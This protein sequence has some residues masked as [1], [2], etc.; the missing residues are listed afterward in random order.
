LFYNFV[1]TS[2]VTFPPEIFSINIWYLVRFDNW[3]WSI[4]T[5]PSILFWVSPVFIYIFAFSN[6]NSQ[7]PIGHFNV[8]SLI[9]NE[10]ILPHLNWIFFVPIGKFL[11]LFLKIYN[12]F[13]FC[14]NVQCYRNLLTVRISCTNSDRLSSKWLM[15]P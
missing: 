13:Y 5:T 10:F 8:P 6:I 11:V 1:L 2:H 7:I 3:I 15:P 9:N 14:K 4:N 12:Q